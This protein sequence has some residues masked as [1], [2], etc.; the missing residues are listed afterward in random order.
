VEGLGEGFQKAFV[1]AIP[2]PSPNQD[3]D[4]DQD[5][6]QEQQQS[7]TVRAAAP[8]AVRP[9]GKTTLV[10]GD[11]AAIEAEI[12]R[13]DVFRH[14]DAHAIAV[15]QD[16]RMMTAGQRLPWVMAAIEE[17]AAKS[18]GLGLLAPELQAKLVGFMRHAK[19][20]RDPEPDEQA[21][22]AA[23]P[24]EPTA[25]PQHLSPDEITKRRAKIAADSAAFDARLAGGKS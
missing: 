13:H 8:S 23:R 14:L 7:A 4:Q 10:G 6:E 25:P 22:L 16:G 3:Q 12:L 9:V 19:R 2:D 21:L 1:K 17:C 5:Q 18:V 24:A 15:V 11:L 20:P